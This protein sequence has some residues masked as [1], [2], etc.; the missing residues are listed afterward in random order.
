[1]SS[2]NRKGRVVSKLKESHSILGT[3]SSWLWLVRSSGWE[4]EN[5]LRI[6]ILARQ[7]YGHSRLEWYLLERRCSCVHIRNARSGCYDQNHFLQIKYVAG[8][9][10]SFAEVKVLLI[11]LTLLHVSSISFLFSRMGIP[12]LNLTQQAF[13]GSAEMISRQMSLE[14]W[15]LIS[16]R[17]NMSPFASFFISIKETS[18]FLFWDV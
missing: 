14:K 13:Y 5:S 18:G 3:D 2:G 9:A 11:V 1:M 8:S 16:Q 17:E 6:K 12:T 4:E 15:I 7:V 10:S